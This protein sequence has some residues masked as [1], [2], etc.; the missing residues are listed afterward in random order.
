MLHAWCVAHAPAAWT[1]VIQRRVFGE[2][3]TPPIYT[4]LT[5]QLSAS[6]SEFSPSPHSHLSL[7]LATYSLQGHKTIGRSSDP[8]KNRRLLN[9]SNKM[10][11]L[12]VP[13]MRPPS[14]W[15]SPPILASP[16]KMWPTDPEYGLSPKNTIGIDVY[17]PPPVSHLRWS[18]PLTTLGNDLFSVSCR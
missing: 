10:P 18:S 16:N 11:S 4:L 8:I 15:L 7:L 17:N 12:S 14:I 3:A 1:K 13:P 6:S 2:E 9:Y 5:K